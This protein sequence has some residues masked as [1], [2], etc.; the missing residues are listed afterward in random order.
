MNE[1]LLSLLVCPRCG[2]GFRWEPAGG[3]PG[4]G[5]LACRRHRYPV[6]EEIPI[7]RAGGAAE[8]AVAAI[9]RGDPAGALGATLRA[10]PGARADRL[11]GGLGAYLLGGAALSPLAAARMGA[12]LHG[13]SA[14]GSFRAQ[15]RMLFG[16]G[17]R[18]APST[19]EGF[20]LHRSD[21]T[22]VA[23]EGLAGRLLPREGAVLE[24][25]CGV[26][27]LAASLGEL[28]EGRLVAGLDPL[29]PALL[30]ARRF[31]SPH[32]AL[33]CADAGTPLPFRD[34]SFGMVICAGAFLDL[35]FLPA[36]AREIARVLPARGG[37]A[38][39]THLPG[40]A[41]AAP[42]SSPE[43]YVEALAPLAV[44]F[45]DEREL[46]ASLV[47]A[48]R[49]AVPFAADPTEL[50]AALRLVAVGGGAPPREIAIEGPV[51]PVAVGP[52]VW[53][54][55]YG[56][57]SV[58]AAE[59]MRVLGRSSFRYASETEAGALPGL[60]PESVRLPLPLE[61]PAYAALTAPDL[62]ASLLAQ[63]VALTLPAGMA[64]ADDPPAGGG[65]RRTR[66]RG[67]PS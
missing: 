58:D 25:A 16:R 30:L 26:G 2:G 67:S 36:A 24:L 35:P 41:S 11:L 50:S 28:A 23:A 9:E 37:V 62:L 12:K 54:P 43:D 21:P 44:S 32:A 17:P 13:D 63:R 39:L 46:L 19:A 66:R 42:A 60:L 59:G 51:L 53:N 49:R 38:C 3:A 22:F 27:H 20:A 7:L 40:L 4:W 48:G 55:L 14:P 18:G 61:S 64:E 15:N 5:L 6:I 1:T 10:A 8:A 29:F 33:V 45:A 52:I 65:G 56:K 57:S 47:G 31:V 34:D